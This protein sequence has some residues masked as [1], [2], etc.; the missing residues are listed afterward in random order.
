MREKQVF[1]D[2]VTVFD[3]EVFTKK[4]GAAWAMSL[5]NAYTDVY[6]GMRAQLNE[7]SPVSFQISRSLLKEVVVD[8][9]IGMRK[10]TESGNNGVKEP[11][12]FKIAAYLSYWW[13]RHKPVYLHHPTGYRLEDAK[14]SP[15]ALNELDSEDDRKKAEDIFH[16][17]LKHINELVAVQFVSTYIFQFDHVVCGK[18]IEITVKKTEGDRFS[19]ES[20]DDMRQELLDKLTYYFAYRALAPKVIEHILE[21]YT[22]HPAWSLTGNLWGGDEHDEGIV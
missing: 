15:A 8:A 12:A 1:Y 4:R 13:L 11:N 16:W 14:L 6:N 3:S 2:Y 7:E 21:A 17:K 10:I 20:F 5:F 22:F 9:V 18:L 19:F